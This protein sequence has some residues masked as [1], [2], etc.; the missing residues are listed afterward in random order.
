[1]ARSEDAKQIARSWYAPF[2]GWRS[3]HL[4]RKECL[5]GLVSAGSAVML[6]ATIG[7]TSARVIDLTGEP[8]PASSS[9]TDLTLQEVEAGIF[10]ACARRGWAARTRAPGIID[11]SITVR[12]KHRAKVEITYDRA[13]FGI[14]YLDSAGL[15]YR[16]GRIHRNYN[17]WVAKL[18]QQIHLQFGTRAQRF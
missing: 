12:T 8:I 10:Q 4:V 3:W 2:S 14:R 1:M 13:H 17:R 6:A 16:N 18:A 5:R 15:E 7:C 9:G 11:A